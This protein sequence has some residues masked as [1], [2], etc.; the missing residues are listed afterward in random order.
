MHAVGMYVCV[1]LAVFVFVFE[2]KFITKS[3]VVALIYVHVA[4][5]IM[6]T[7]IYHFRRIVLH[8][9]KYCMPLF[10]LLVNMKHFT[11]SPVAA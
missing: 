1:R 10:L 4:G 2:N 8:L 9:Q 3:M 11:I 6:H 5:Y 7:L